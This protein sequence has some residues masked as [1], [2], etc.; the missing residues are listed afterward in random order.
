[1]FL[2]LCTCPFSSRAL[3]VITHFQF[4]FCGNLDISL[5]NALIHQLQPH[6]S[7][8]IIIVKASLESDSFSPSFSHQSRLKSELLARPIRLRALVSNMTLHADHSVIPAD[9]FKDATTDDD[10]VQARSLYSKQS[11]AVCVYLSTMPASQ[12]PPAW[13][14]FDLDVQPSISLEY[15]TRSLKTRTKVFQLSAGITQRIRKQFVLLKEYNKLYG[16]GES[17]VASE[18]SLMIIIMIII[19]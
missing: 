19:R 1:M 18:R 14:V 2:A 5:S 11:Q 15:T 4:F 17:S 6:L 9:I 13:N 12:G 8:T 7:C 10:S 3:H 16:P